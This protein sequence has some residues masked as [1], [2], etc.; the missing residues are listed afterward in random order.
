[1]FSSRRIKARCKPRV[2]VHDLSFEIVRAGVVPKL[3]GPL[4]SNT[5]IPRPPTKAVIDEYVD[6]FSIAAANA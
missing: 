5:T 3:A 1:M 6:I 4:F 2:H